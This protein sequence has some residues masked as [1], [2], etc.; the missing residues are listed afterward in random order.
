MKKS[1]LSAFA[2]L[3]TAVC[4]QSAQAAPTAPD[5]TLKD[6]SGK[7][8]TVSSFRGKSPVLLVFSA[9]WCP[10]CRRQIPYLIDLRKKIQVQDLAI[11]T[12]DVAEP[13]D[14][15]AA[16]VASKGINYP[17]LLDPTNKVADLYG[18]S[19][20]PFFVLI[21]RD[22]NV[23]ATDY[24]VSRRLVDKINSLIK[25]KSSPKKS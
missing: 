1:F 3:M 21:D 16:F 22:G 23:A 25:P 9:T 13:R 12:I 8:V 5:F 20:I 10:Y 24:G 19:G 17:V 11:Y 2:V 7:S 14:K 15:V 6:L 18:A 4:L